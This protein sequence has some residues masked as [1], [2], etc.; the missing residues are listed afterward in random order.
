M[1][2][3]E[4]RSDLEAFTHVLIIRLADEVLHTIREAITE[5]YI[6]G[7]CPI[8]V[9]VQVAYKDGKPATAEEEED[10]EGISYQEAHELWCPASLI[11]KHFAQVA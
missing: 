5:E 8:C 11:D 1:D 6:A 9:H 2:T 10:G 4:N 3:K 7:W